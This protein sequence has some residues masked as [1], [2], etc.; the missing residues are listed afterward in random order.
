MEVSE[1]PVSRSGPVPALFGGNMPVSLF[2]P[3]SAEKS[4]FLHEIHGFPFHGQRPKRSKSTRDATGSPEN[5]VASKVK[6][7]FLWHSL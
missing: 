2:K 1:H 3:V 4:T 7:P 6:E 5:P